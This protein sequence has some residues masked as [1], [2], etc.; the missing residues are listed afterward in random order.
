MNTVESLLFLKD[1]FTSFTFLLKRAARDVAY[2][3][4]QI[5]SAQANEIF[6]PII[7]NH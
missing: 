6:S 4:C 3:E 7:Q 2:G 5:L 1:T